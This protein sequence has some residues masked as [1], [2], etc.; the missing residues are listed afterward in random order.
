MS[1]N[2]FCFAKISLFSATMHLLIIALAFSLSLFNEQKGGVVP[3]AIPGE[4]APDLLDGSMIG[5]VG[6]DR[7]SLSTKAD[8][9]ALTSTAFFAGSAPLMV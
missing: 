9:I 6:F 3:S 8:A 7:A 1:K 2:R 4:L 5:D